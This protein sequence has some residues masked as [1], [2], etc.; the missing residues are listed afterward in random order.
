M[1]N[2]AI[3]VQSIISSII[4]TIIATLNDIFNK[5]TLELQKTITTTT[6]S[7]QQTIERLKSSKLRV[8]ICIKNLLPA[9]YWEC[10]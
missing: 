6:L 3:Q 7:E 4:A 5:R 2:G 1:T 9:F 8:G 10:K